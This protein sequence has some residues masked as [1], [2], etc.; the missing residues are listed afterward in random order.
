LIRIGGKDQEVNDKLKA[1][2]LWMREHRI[3]KDKA[4]KAL[5][6]FRMVYHRTSQ[7][8][9]SD[10]LNTM[11]PDMRLDF[12]TQLYEQFLREIP[13][14]RGLSVALIHSVCGIASPML[15]VRHQV[16]YAEG[17]TGK[18]MY[19]LINGELEITAG[20]ERL[21]FLS[22]GAFF[23]ETPVLDET[24]HSEVRRRTVTAM[25]DSKLCFIHKD[26]LKRVAARYPE[27]A[28][29]MKRLGRA[30]AKVNKKG[31]KFHAALTEAMSLPGFAHSSKDR[32]STST[33]E[34]TAR[35]SRGS[36]SARTNVLPEAVRNQLARQ[37]EQLVE[38]SAQLK[39]QKELLKTVVDALHKLQVAVAT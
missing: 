33:P 34:R 38:Q 9:E 32:S 25:V 18:E 6:Y 15:A 39:E 17:S 37:Q 14:F 4:A 2:K 7:Y 12:S 8:E 3:P 21:G 26:A 24:A 10:I 31:R 1:A 23:G 36:E 16:I 22:D 13:L 35:N 29:R 20:G 19:I 30:E 11:P 27:L 28:L 5:E